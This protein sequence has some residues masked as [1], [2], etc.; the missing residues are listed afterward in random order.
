MK[1]LLFIQRQE[2]PK[3]RVSLRFF[4]VFYCNII[5]IFVFF[6]ARPFNASATPAEW[7][8]HCPDPA[9][10]G[11]QI[12]SEMTESFEICPLISHWR[13]ST[14]ILSGKFIADGRNPT[15]GAPP[16]GV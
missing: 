11:L 7:T 4:Y 1:H 14:R 3:G 15:K 9:T 2:R 5:Y 12:H 6:I 13:R 16:Q 10:A 8:M